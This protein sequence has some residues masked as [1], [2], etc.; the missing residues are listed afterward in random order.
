[1]HFE[2][3]QAYGAGQLVSTEKS[4]QDKSSNLPDGLV[5]PG[6]R[7]SFIN[8]PPQHRVRWLF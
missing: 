7:L 8:I 6:L 2:L 5:L 4:C 1:M 3:L